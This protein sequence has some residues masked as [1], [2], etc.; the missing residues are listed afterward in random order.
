MWI[1]QALS[2]VVT[3]GLPSATLDAVVDAVRKKVRSHKPVLINQ[4]GLRAQVCFFQPA[5]RVELERDPGLLIRNH[6]A[7]IKF[8]R[9]EVL[10][11]PPGSDSESA[12][13]T[14]QMADA[15][16]DDE[17]MGVNVPDTLAELE[18]DG[19]VMS[20]WL[21][22]MPDS[23][24]L[25]TCSADGAFHEWQ[26]KSTF[27]HPEDESVLYLCLQDGFFL[28][29]SRLSTRCAFDR[30]GNMPALTGFNSENPESQKNDGNWLESLTTTA[31]CAASAA[32][33][34]TGSPVDTWVARVCSELTADFVSFSF[35]NSASPSHFYPT[36]ETMRMGVLSVPN[37]PWPASLKQVEGTHYQ[38]LFRPKDQEKMDTKIDEG[39]FAGEMKDHKMLS[40]ETLKGVLR[41]VPM[42]RQ[43]ALQF[44][45]HVHPQL[46]APNDPHILSVS[47]GCSQVPA[48]VFHR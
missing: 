20:L 39:E 4:E 29:A 30:V 6:F 1:G 22:K 3:S 28:G 19:K 21:K 24:L 43:R 40:M 25:G 7:H 48:E 18:N 5:S 41:R 10:S 8:P 38:D 2:G 36:L 33:G 32:E 17:E 46:H 27:P 14:S 11:P 42:V 16:G 15:E 31:M 9:G 12:M 34:S 37:G 45:I 35:T 47:P 44:R 23:L 26:P 13:E